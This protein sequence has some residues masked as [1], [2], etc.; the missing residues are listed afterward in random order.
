[1]LFNAQLVDFLG[2]STLFLYSSPLKHKYFINSGKREWEGHS[3]GERRAELVRF[4]V[5]LC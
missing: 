1:M 4:W 2:F 3:A 5:S